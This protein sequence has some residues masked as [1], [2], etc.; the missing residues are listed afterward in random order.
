MLPV[1]GPPLHD[2]AVVVRDGAI[3]AV[4]PSATVE[5]AHPGLPV[6]DLSGRTLLPG[7][8]DAHCH[9]EWA[10]LPLDRP[11]SSFGAWLSDFLPRRA[12]MEEDDHALAAGLAALALTLAG[13]TTVADN[14]PTGAGIA[15]LEAAGLRGVV[16]LETFG[17]PAGPAADEAARTFERRVEALAERAGR[18]VTVGLSPHAPYTVGPDHWAALAAR[19]GLSG[20]PWSTHL[21]ESAD[22]LRLM[23]EGDGPLFEAYE[24]MG[25][26]PPRWDGAPAAGTVARLAAAGALRQGLLAAHCVEVGDAEIAAMAKAGVAA[27][28]CPLSN[29]GLGCGRMPLRALREGGVTVGLG[30]DSPASGGTYDLR[31]EARAAA[32]MHGAETDPGDL[33]ALATI[34]GARALGLDGSIGSITPGKRADLIA[35][36]PPEG[37]EDPVAAV[38]A[39]AASVDLVMVDGE[40]LAEGGE[41][42]HLDR[43]KTLTR[44]AGARR[45]LC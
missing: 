5:A 29:L 14:G 17:A 22:E 20:R 39:A 33:L 27:V 6:R 31:A 25:F 3:V 40:T 44:A 1:E 45:R 42:L 24:P 11:A 30:S 2:G 34:E 35:V 26:V 41:T 43:E 28:H 9:T 19:P 8:V 10:L 7:L 38:L 18:R 4:G 15:A 23:R 36:A 16:H 13:T 32:A 37:T 12:R 21:A